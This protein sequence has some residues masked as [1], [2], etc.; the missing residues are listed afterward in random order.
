ML[1]MT[2]RLVTAMPM[3]M[4][5]TRGTTPSSKW[6][7][8]VVPR[9]APSRTLN[10]VVVSAAATEEVKIAPAKRRPNFPFSYVSLT[11]DCNAVLHS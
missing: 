9:V 10:T 7:P 3:P 2:T 4:A 11:C 5:S 1:P 6:T 8:A